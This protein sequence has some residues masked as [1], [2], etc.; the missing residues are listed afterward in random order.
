LKSKKSAIFTLAVLLSC[1]IP[2]AFSTDDTFSVVYSFEPVTG[3]TQMQEIPGEPV[4]PYRAAVI[5]LPQDAVV[6][7]VK[8][9]TSEPTIQ[10]GFDIPW[11]QPPCT[12]SDTPVKVGRNEEVYNSMNWY[13]NEI[14]N[15]V[16]V[17]SFRGFQIL[18]MIL[19]PI[20]YQGKTETV[21][22]YET[23]TVTVQFQEGPRNNLYR[24]LVEDK[25]DVTAV[26][27]N[28]EMVG[29][30]EDRPSPLQVEEYIIITSDELKSTFQQLADFRASHF[31]GASVYTVGWISSAYDGTDDPEKIR[32]FITD[33]YLNHGTRY[34]L[35]GGDV[36]AVPYRGFYV[37]SGEYTDFDMLADMYYAHLDGTF[38][39]DN[40]SYWAE[41]DDGIDWYA[42][43][44]VG[45][46]PC[47]NI[48]EAR[49]FVNKAI[50]YDYSG[51]P[52]RI[53]LHQS[54]VQSGNIPDSRLV[55]YNC[56]NYIPYDYT[57]D[58]LFEENGTVSKS[59]W[60]SHW[61]QNP[62][63]V[64]HVG[65]GTSTSYCINYEVVGTVTWCNSDVSDLTNTFW[66]WHTSTACR[67][68]EIE[69]NDC[70]A[71]AYVMDAKNGA[72]ACIHNDNYGWYSPLDGFKYSGEYCAM[73]CK[74]CWSD[75]KNRLGEVLNQARNYLVPSAQTDS[76][77]RWCFYERNLIGD[78]G[79][80]ALW[81]PPRPPL[82][83]L[84][85]TCPEYGETVY[86]TI[87][88]T[89]S[90]NA[91]CIDMIEFYIDNVL[92]YTDTDYPLE[93]SWDTTAF[94]DG[95]HTIEVKGYFQGQYMKSDS[96]VVTV[97]NSTI[98]H[99]TII[100]PQDRQE[101]SGSVLVTTDTFGID[102]V[103]FYLNGELKHTDTTRPF[104]WDWNISQY[105]TRNYK[106]KAEGYCRGT[107]MA[108][109]Q[110]KV[111]LKVSNHHVVVLSLLMLFLTAGIYRKY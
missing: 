8:V 3:Y 56:D 105:K 28:P 29:T 89:A 75:G 76:T 86:R 53:L 44:A 37:S 54:R 110:V 109:D 18:T 60:I 22:S 90:W 40:D 95:D 21:K 32:N 91:C 46:A 26:V 73:E 79:T 102:E 106:L 33:L 107:L 104:T 68:G 51:K 9:T 47:E 65:H 13:P 2:A 49:N 71:E 36:A 43:V 4:L 42:E 88:I 7:D 61:A 80:G 69:S 94:T 20:Q 59:V 39:D 11:G 27:D 67:T 74:A 87:T 23:M 101:I 111:K 14:Y 50:K 24:G 66:P 98:P 100:Y 77:Y 17:E 93:Y 38:N 85:I 84:I 58:Y 10:S 34:V 62:V 25:Q 1:G 72:I 83:R 19:Y 82:L 41:P 103:R 45:R 64:V 108:S 5:L 81:N 30:Y 57:I 48:A 99:V 35:L 52:K 78:P 97:D 6:E 70:L 12:F 15:V 31:T 96:I 16:S 63:A 92:L 55:A